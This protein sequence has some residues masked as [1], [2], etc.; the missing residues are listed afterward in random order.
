MSISSIKKVLGIMAAVDLLLLIIFCSALSSNA[1]K[2]S[3]KVLINN[4]G[5]FVEDVSDVEGT[6][7]DIEETK[8][9]IIVSTV[10]ESVKASDYAVSYN[11]LKSESFRDRIG[12]NTYL[13]SDSLKF[14]FGMDGT[15]EGFYD[16][17]MTDVSGCSYNI[18]TDDGGATYL[19]I[20]SPDGTSSVLYRLGTSA[21]GN[22]TLY[23]EAADFT[24]ELIPIDRS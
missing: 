4:L 3:K 24:M 15:Y 8:P 11:E 2:K 17:K 18:F 12:G 10:T 7:T 6:V 19:Q 20:F 1:A 14:V 16:S 22:V 23:Y 5:H 9:E 13:V 21:A